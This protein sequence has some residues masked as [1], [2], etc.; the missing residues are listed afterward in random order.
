MLYAERSLDTHDSNSRAT[1]PYTEEEQFKSN[2]EGHAICPG[3][4]VP[5]KLKNL[6]MFS[7]D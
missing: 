5:D 7:Y 6:C 1:T 3:S 4:E 2:T